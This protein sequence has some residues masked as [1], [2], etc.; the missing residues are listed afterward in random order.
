MD[1]KKSTLKFQ[2]DFERNHLVAIR[3]LY[4]FPEE[5]LWC[6]SLDNKNY[7]VPKND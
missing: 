6:S 3:H 5:K 2:L 4:A 7:F 1:F